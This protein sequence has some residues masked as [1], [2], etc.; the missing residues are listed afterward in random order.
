MTMMM[1]MDINRLKNLRL[2]NK[3]DLL[4]SCFSFEFHM[5]VSSRSLFSGQQCVNVR[6]IECLQM[7]TLNKY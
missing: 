4:S 7:C 1:A 2:G 3:M 6:D 5:Y